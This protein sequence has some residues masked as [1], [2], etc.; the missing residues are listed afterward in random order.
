MWDDA[1]LSDTRLRPLPN[2]GATAVIDRYSVVVPPGTRGPV[3]VTAAVYYQSFEGVVAKK[4]LGNLADQNGNRQL[5]PCVLGGLCDGRTP[6]VEPA[7][8][9][10]APPVPMEVRS[11]VIDVRGGATDTIPPGLRTYPGDSAK[12]IA[13]DVVPKAFFSEPVTGV[14]A[15]TFTLTDDAG[16]PV[17]A[18]VDAVGDGAWA[19]FPHQVFLEPDRTYTA[20]VA[21]GVCDLH[22]NC[23]RREVAWR[24][25]TGENAGEGTGDTRV[26]LG[27]PAASPPPPEPPLAVAAV[28]AGK[29]D[30]AVDVAFSRPVLNV[31]PLTFQVREGD[32]GG[33]PLLPGH[34]SASP[35][36]DR[37]AFTP[38][39]PPRPDR[40]LC[41]TLSPK[42]YDLK[43]RA[44]AGPVVKKLR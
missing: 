1:F 15:S 29:P 38:E 5:E 4:L 40:R 39:R 22:R 36:G 16:S 41:L 44:L 20:R 13:R 37:W 19:L 34:L 42:I 43:G 21:A 14:D 26:P 3:A 25:T 32:C 18:F 33:G 9:E 7:V 6:S 28:R 30:G 27:F 11:L 35:A 31:T 17:P 2:R 24:F 23:T 10:G 12:G 8:V